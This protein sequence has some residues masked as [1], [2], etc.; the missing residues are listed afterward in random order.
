MAHLT[1]NGSCEMGRSLSPAFPPFPPRQ[2]HLASFCACY[3]GRFC[4]IEQAEI[5]PQFATRLSCFAV[6]TCQLRQPVILSNI[7][8][9]QIRIQ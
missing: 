6:Q 9:P 5:T 7:T 3:L 4:L 2:T 8:T 1:K